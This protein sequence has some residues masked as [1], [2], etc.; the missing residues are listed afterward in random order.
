M[1]DF[2]FPLPAMGN[3]EHNG[4]ILGIDCIAGMLWQGKQ[5]ANGRLHLFQE[6][7]ARRLI[8]KVNARKVEGRI[9]VINGIQKPDEIP[10]LPPPRSQQRMGMGV[11]GLQ[12]N[13]REILTVPKRMPPPLGVEEFASCHDISPVIT[14]GVGYGQDDL[15]VGGKR[16][17][18][19]QGT[20]GQGSGAKND[21]PSR[22]RWQ[23]G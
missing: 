21:D 10:S 15:G 5:V 8:K 16:Y 14:T 18:N 11:H 20:P 4:S 7:Y 12:G 9:G 1:E 22:Q 23:L 3:M 6:R 2:H 13:C 19:V 17:Q